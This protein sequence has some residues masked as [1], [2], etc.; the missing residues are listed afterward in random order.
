VAK[1][2]ILVPAVTFQALLNRADPEQRPHAHQNSAGG[3]SD[4]ILLF[5]PLSKFS[6]SLFIG[7]SRY[8]NAIWRFPAHVH[9]QIVEDDKC[10]G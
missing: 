8:I 3:H 6:T 9:I 5:D 10:L 1:I 7:P 4:D 2:T